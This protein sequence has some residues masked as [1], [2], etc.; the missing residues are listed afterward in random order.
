MK[1]LGPVEV[2]IAILVAIVSSAWLLSAQMSAK[3]VQLEYITKQVEHIAVN[4]TKQGEQITNVEKD[5]ILLN[6]YMRPVVVFD[7]GSSK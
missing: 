1:W 4:Q 6:T 3:T 5:I 7:D 2:A